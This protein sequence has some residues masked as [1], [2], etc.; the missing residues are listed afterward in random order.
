MIINSF[1]ILTLPRDKRGL[2]GLFRGTTFTRVLKSKIGKSLNKGKTTSKSY[3]K[4][5][6]KRKR[7]IL[8]KLRFIFR[9]IDK[10]RPSNCKS[11]GKKYKTTETL[12][13]NG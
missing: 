10:L 2:E 5:E 9:S 13:N 4:R 8:K 1:Q 12:K 3:S 6:G 7:L 11:K